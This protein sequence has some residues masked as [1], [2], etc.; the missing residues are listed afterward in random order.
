[1]KLDKKQTELDLAKWHKSE[2]LGFDA[3]GSF[4]FCYHCDKSK[5]YPCARACFKMD[6]VEVE[7]EVI[8]VAVIEDKKEVVEEIPAKVSKATKKTS[9]KSTSAKKSTTKKTTTK[10]A[11]TKKSK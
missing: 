8:P 4:N 11:S 2:R 9:T 10:K 7:D 6:G 1:M 3:C 5:S